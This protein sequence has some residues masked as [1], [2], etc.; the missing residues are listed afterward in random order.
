[1]PSMLP[2]AQ[3]VMRQRA[4]DIAILHRGDLAGFLPTF[5]R[6][7][8][9]QVWT[10]TLWGNNNNPGAARLVACRH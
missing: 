2:L 3:T 8:A 9:R 1:M 6:T 7:E 10:A 4:D 5:A